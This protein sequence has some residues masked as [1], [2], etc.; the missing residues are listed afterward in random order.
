MF[1]LKKS[2]GL[3]NI[4][5]PTIGNLAQQPE[6]K[7]WFGHVSINSLSPS[8]ELEIETIEGAIPTDKQIESIIDLPISYISTLGLLFG[9]LE[10]SSLGKDFSRQELE[11]MYFLAAINL[12]EDNKTWWY[13]LEPD[14][15]VTSIYNFFIRFT[16]INDVVIWCNVN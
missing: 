2:Q 15:S 9:Y 16:V 11:Q 7:V 12:K 14:I 10:N 1:N 8:I 3:K 5:I 6:S 4:A 13:V